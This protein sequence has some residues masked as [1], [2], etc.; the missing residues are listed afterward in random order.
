[1]QTSLHVQRDCKVAADQP[2]QSQILCGAMLGCFRDIKIV[3]V[4]TTFKKVFNSFKY[5]VEST[6]YL[7]ELN[8]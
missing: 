4:H 7:K 2:V 3:T 8:I 1:M 6:L 5:S